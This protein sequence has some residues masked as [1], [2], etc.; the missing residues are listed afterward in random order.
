MGCASAK[1]NRVTTTVA[2][3]VAVCH[4]TQTE[5]IVS[6]LEPPPVIIEG[7]K[8]PRINELTD[9]DIDKGMVS[10][11]HPGNVVTRDD[12]ATITKEV[13]LVAPSSD[14]NGSAVSITLTTEGIEDIKEDQFVKTPV[15]VVVRES[16]DWMKRV[17][18][19]ENE[20]QKLTERSVENP[21]EIFHYQQNIINNSSSS[22][23]SSNSIEDLV[24]IKQDMEMKPK[25]EE[26]IN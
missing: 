23:S 19:V 3:V 14:M 8:P 10:M 4:R 15:K 24:G 7:E 13:Q 22:S 16:T 6:R 5:N 11:H 12:F 18:S 1:A 21:S 2:P 25:K 26:S 9:T 20:F 17:T